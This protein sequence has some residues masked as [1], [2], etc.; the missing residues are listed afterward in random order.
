MKQFGT[1]KSELNYT[2]HLSLFGNKEV[3]KSYQVPV[4]SRQAQNKCRICSMYGLIPSVQKVDSIRRAPAIIQHELFV[5]M[6]MLQNLG[7]SPQHYSVEHRMDIL[8]LVIKIRNQLTSKGFLFF[9]ILILKKKMKN[10]RTK[11]L[12]KHSGTFSLT[13]YKKET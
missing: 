13:V 7:G 6:Y 12:E 9:E 5:Y 8:K 4:C 3:Y 2:K 1:K 11:E 10:V